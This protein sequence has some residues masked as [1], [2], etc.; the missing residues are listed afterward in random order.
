MFSFQQC[1][2]KIPTK[3]LGD[4]RLHILFSLADAYS[5]KAIDKVVDHLAYRI[6]YHI[7]NLERENKNV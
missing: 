4:P 3:Y 7:H 6:A 2:T 1:L 5:D